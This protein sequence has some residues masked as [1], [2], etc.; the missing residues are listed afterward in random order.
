M[1]HKMPLQGITLYFIESREDRY[2]HLQ[3]LLATMT[4]P[5]QIKVI[6]KNSRFDE[7]LTEVLNV[8]DEQKKKLAPSFAFIDPFGYSHA[9]LNV[10]KR[11]MQNQR[12]EVLITFMYEEINRFWDVESERERLDGL[13]GC[14]RP[15]LSSS[16]PSGERERVIHSLYASQLRNEAGSKY[17]RS[18]R[19]VNSGNKTD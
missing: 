6:L 19:M 9:P 7:P 2:D 12:C 16:T 1:D 8:L 14:E 17:V 10:V 11:L 18:F 15:T 3:Q 13:F 5:I 4:I